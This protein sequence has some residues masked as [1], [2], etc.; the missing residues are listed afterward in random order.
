MLAMMQAAEPRAA[1]IKELTELV[2]EACAPIWSK[3]K[4]R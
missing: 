2:G 3:P 1:R 4:K